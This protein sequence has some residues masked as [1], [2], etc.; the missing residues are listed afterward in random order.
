MAEKCVFN[1]DSDCVGFAKAEEL[2]KEVE[3]LRK[4]NDESHKEFYNRISVLESH[5]QVQD[6]HYEHI[7]EKLTDVTSKLS[8]ISKRLAA[9]ELKPA[10]K[11]ESTVEKVAWA[12]I[13]AVL[14]L[15][16]TKIGLA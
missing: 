6:A 1:P 7:I 2:K 8:D 12:L 9:L 10:K 16:L 3:E 5:N 4:H 13:A 11:W 14:T 15:A